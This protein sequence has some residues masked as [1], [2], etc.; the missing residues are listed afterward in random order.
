MIKL[1]E[2]EVIVKVRKEDAALVR[3]LIATCEQEFEDKMLS[4]TNQEYKC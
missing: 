3:S 4:E 2:P 1:L